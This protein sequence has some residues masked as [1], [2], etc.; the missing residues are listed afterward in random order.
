MTGVQCP[1]DSQ[2][3]RCRLTSGLFGP[4]GGMT[5]GVVQI[6]G[7]KVGVPRERGIRTLGCVCRV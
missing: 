1:K 3:R 7:M 4:I 2:R 6:R 5:R